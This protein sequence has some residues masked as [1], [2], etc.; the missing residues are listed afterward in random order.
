MY[1][2][3]ETMQEHVF[4]KVQ[5]HE[6]AEDFKFQCITNMHMK[7]LGTNINTYKQAR[8]IPNMNEKPYSSRIKH[9]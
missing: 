9:T 6:P 2:D 3:L 7:Q 8:D 1:N 5:N 4:D